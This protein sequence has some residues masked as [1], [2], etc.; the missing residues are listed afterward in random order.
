M[1]GLVTRNG[2]GHE[3][4]EGHAVLGVDVEQRG[5]DSGEL[6]PLA[7]DLRADEE[8]RRHV[9][10]ALA[11]VDQRPERTELI[12]RVEVDPL[13]VLGE[14][15]LLGRDGRAR[16]AHVAGHGRGLCEALGLH[17]Q[18]QGAITPTPAGTS[19]SPVS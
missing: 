19:N 15:V 10:D 14:A 13:G 11:G 5:C 6:E 7:H 9:L 18:L 8:A 16:L 12:E 4:V 3:L 1:A 17:Q 2:E